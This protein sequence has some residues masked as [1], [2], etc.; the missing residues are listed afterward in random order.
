MGSLS[1][2]PGM[3]PYLENPDIW[4]GFHTPFFVELMTGLNEI[5]PPNYQAKVDRYLWIHEPE[6]EERILLGNL[7]T[8]W[9]S[10][11]R[12]RRRHEPPLSRR[13]KP[14]CYPRF[15]WKETDTS[16]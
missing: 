10:E 16:R 11:E 14:S 5:L 13:R 15:D 8:T 7:D 9:R 3:D 4:S 12:S 6:A 2:F 1:P